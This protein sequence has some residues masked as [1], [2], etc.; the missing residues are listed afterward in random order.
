MK[1]KLHYVFATAIYFM[2]FSTFAQDNFFVKVEDTQKTKASKNTLEESYVYAFDYESLS[3]ALPKDDYSSNS[4]KSFETVISFPNADGD[5]EK[6]NIQEAPVFHPDLQK[7]YPEIRS[8]IAQGIEIPSAVFRFTLSPYKG[9]SGIILGKDTAEVIEPLEE[10]N[11]FKISKVSSLEKITT[12]SCK[13]IDELSSSINRKSTSLKDAD[14]SIK[15]VY[16]I[17]ISVTGEYSNFHGGTLAG[18]NAA[19]AST[20]NNINAVFENDFN[21]ALQLTGNNDNVIYLNPASDPYSSFGNYA[22]ELQTTLDNEIGDANY[23][24]GHLLAASG[25][26]GN[27]GC[28][29]CVCDSGIKGRGYTSSDTPDGFNFD[30]DLVAHEIGHQFGANHTWTHGGNEGSNVQM[31]PG[32]GSTIM[33]YA[34]ITGSTNVQVNS[35]PYFHGISIEQVTNFIK[36]TTCALETNTGNTT[37]VANAGPDLTLPVGT[38]FKLVGSGSDADG[39]NLTYCWEQIDEDNAL[40]TFP[41]PDDTNSNSVLFRSFSPS[42]SSTRYFPNLSDLQYGVNANQWEK[43][44]NVARTSDFRLTVRDNRAGGANNISDDMRVTFDNSRGPFQITSQNT[45]GLFWTSGSTQTI[46]WSVNNTNTI[47]G[48]ANVNILLS[49]DGGATYNLVAEDVPNNGSYNLTVPN[50]PSTSCRVMVEAA[51]ETFFAINEE[52][53]AIDFEVTTTCTQYASSD[54]LNISI[55]DN[56]GSLSE[57]NSI[58]I[59]DSSTITDVNVGLNISH[60]YIGDLG[61]ALESPEGTTV[62]LKT[63]RDCD[64]EQNFVITFDDE[65]VQLN[66]LQTTGNPAYR[67]VNDLLSTLNGENTSGNWTINVGDFQPGDSGTLNS[68]F[69]EVCQTTH[70]SLNITEF[71][72]ENVK[73]FPNP[74]NGEFTLKIDNQHIAK[75][76]SI[77]VFDLRGRLVYTQQIQDTTMLEETVAI[78]NAQGGMYVMR[79]TDGISKDIRKIVVK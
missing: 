21:V 64:S 47:S 18:V 15:R 59:S 26:D 55:T 33:G 20:L 44:P 4:S 43:V 38:P 31:E 52:A 76:I 11:K 51:N 12:F 30:I 25:F 10:K 14:D 23:D 60:T 79:L 7:K 48:A 50:K 41:D 77:E 19:L 3:K 58:N 40:T 71:S 16:T 42:T 34:G 1:T 22:G 2:V 56:T 28:I 67:S 32:S 49:T 73:L 74:S 39:D 29:G 65:A 27:A 17:A 72:F 35:D 5:L 63:S 53:F 66:C 75:N 45:P 8:Y 6:F 13:T 54:N 70:T 24:V 61:I 68:W 36:T 9:L 57:S 69:I 37:P 46:T 78:K 62:S